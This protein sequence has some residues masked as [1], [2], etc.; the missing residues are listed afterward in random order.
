MQNFIRARGQVRIILLRNGK[1]VTE[2][3]SE[4]LVVDA[5][6]AHIADQLSASPDQ[7]EMSHMAI[8]TGTTAPAASDTALEN[9][10]A[11]V[12][13]ESRTDSESSIVYK[14]EFGAGTGTGAITEAGI[15]NASSGGTMLARDTFD[16]VNKGS[17]DVLRIEWTITFQAA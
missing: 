4:N 10:V 5:G 3:N 8:G 7:A 17:N 13:L 9:E 1:I 2:Q 6:L 14:A 11:R 15:F 12:A 16:V